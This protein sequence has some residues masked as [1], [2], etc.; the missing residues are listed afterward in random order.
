MLVESMRWTSGDGS[1]CPG[2]QSMKRSGPSWSRPKWPY[3]LYLILRVWLFSNLIMPCRNFDDLRN[4]M[5]LSKEAPDQASWEHNK[6]PPDFRL[7]WFM[8]KTCGK[9]RIR[10]LI[11]KLVIEE[12]DLDWDTSASCWDLTSQSITGPPSPGTEMPMLPGSTL[13]R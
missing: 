11:W 1:F 12:T 8:L 4:A 2:Q 3:H 9:N 5:I 7:L 6:L 13:S 10:D